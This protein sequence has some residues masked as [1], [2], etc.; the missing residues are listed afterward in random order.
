MS[1]QFVSALSDRDEVNEM[2]IAS[3]KQLRPNRNGESLFT[4]SVV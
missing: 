1:R 3:E 2:F 4:S